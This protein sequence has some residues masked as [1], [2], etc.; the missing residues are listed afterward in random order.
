MIT[1]VDGVCLTARGWRSAW[2][3]S[4]MKYPEGWEWDKL[5]SVLD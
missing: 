4:A 3:K 2:A 1:T 5:N